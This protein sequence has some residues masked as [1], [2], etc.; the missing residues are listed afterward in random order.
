MM[1]H[2][3][4]MHAVTII[5]TTTKAVGN[6]GTVWLSAY[7]TTSGMPSTTASSASTT[8]IVPKNRSGCQSLK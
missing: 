4:A 3:T 2:V 7:S 1:P 8:P 5:P 6:R